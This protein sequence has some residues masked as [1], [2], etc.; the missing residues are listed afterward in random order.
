MINDLWYKNAIIY[1]VSVGAYLDSDGD[2]IGD[3]KGVT[4]PSVKNRTL[5]ASST[6]QRL[7]SLLGSAARRGSMSA[8]TCWRQLTIIN[9]LFLA[10][11]LENFLRALPIL[12]CV[13]QHNTADQRSRLAAV[14]LAG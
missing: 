3:F 12:H 6:P 4:A 11:T 2:G 13:S 5:T 9:L 1:C 7:R 10:N 8:L 14:S